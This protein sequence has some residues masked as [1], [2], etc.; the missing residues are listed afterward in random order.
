VGAIEYQ[1]LVPIPQKKTP[2]AQN[3]DSAK[4]I[5]WVPARAIAART[6]HNDVI[7]ILTTLDSTQLP[8]MVA[9]Q[10]YRLRW[11]I[12]LLFKRLKS[13]L[14]LTRFPPAGAQRRKVGCCTLPGRGSRAPFSPTVRPTFPLRIRIAI[15]R[16]RA[17]R[18]ALV[19]VSHDTL[20]VAQGGS[21]PGPWLM[22]A[23]E[24]NLGRLMNSPRQRQQAKADDWP[25]RIPYF[26]AYG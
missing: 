11:Q 5:A 25:Q 3:L 26:N 19:A 14:H 16:K 9:M 10:L 4:A 7:W 23:S 21:R 15:K 12:E 2:K 20:G 6:R 8:A 13:L 18:I 24:R 1:I 22:I 17:T